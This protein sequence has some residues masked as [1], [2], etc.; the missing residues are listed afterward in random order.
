MYCVH[1]GNLLGDGDI[2]CVKCGRRVRSAAY[3]EQMYAG[4]R[5]KTADKYL[6]IFFCVFFGW[7][8]VHRFYEGKIITGAIWLTTCGL[9]GVGWLVDLVLLIFKKER[10][11]EP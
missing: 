6:S 3:Y 2:F 5:R 7:A 8:G 10:Y 4:R 11:Y 1:C 9:F